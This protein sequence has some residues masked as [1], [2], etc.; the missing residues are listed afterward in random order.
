[1][2]HSVITPAPGRIVVRPFDALDPESKLILPDTIQNGRNT[3]GIVAAVH[4][5]PQS[6][7]VQTSVEEEFTTKFFD[8][9]FIKIGAQVVF[10]AMSGTEISL[11][12]P[13]E[14]NKRHMQRY[15]VLREADVIALIESPVPIAEA[16]SEPRGF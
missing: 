2:S 15:I 8:T 11:P 16:S 3:T 9:E 10:S 12:E 4:Y 14:K 13:T 5:G 6:V 7:M 1:M